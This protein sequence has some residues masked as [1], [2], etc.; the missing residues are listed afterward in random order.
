M[1]DENGRS[2]RKGLRWW[3]KALALAAVLAMLAAL[4]IEGFVWVRGDRPPTPAGAAA[5]STGP[6]ATPGMGFV[7][8]ADGPGQVEPTA[9]VSPASDWTRYS[10][11]VFRAGGSFLIGFVVA[12]VVRRV[13]HLAAWM[14]VAAF[15]GVVVLQY[16]GVSVIDTSQL[17]DYGKRAVQWLGLEMKDFQQFLT[18][19][20]PSTV[21]AA[22][23]FA[24]GFTR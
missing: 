3:Q 19:Q 2:E 6:A 8:S 22:L 11:Q 17:G 5:R 12:F 10:P 16:V 13:L 21:A 24:V 20:L 15:A 4:A 14:A 7:G 1:S 23:G 9:E 18:R